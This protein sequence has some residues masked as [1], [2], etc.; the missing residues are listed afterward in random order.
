M[1]LNKKDQEQ[2]QRGYYEK[3]V[4]VNRFNG[5]LWQVYSGRPKKWDTMDDIGALRPTRDDRVEEL[6]PGFVGDFH[7]GQHQHQ[8]LRAA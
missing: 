2:L 8:F 5:E 6:I 7:G 4:G 1:Q 3:I